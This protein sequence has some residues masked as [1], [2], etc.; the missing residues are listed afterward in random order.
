MS[1]SLINGVIWGAVVALFAF[2]MYGQYQLALVMLTAMIVNLLIAAAAGVLVPAL[3]KYVG[4]D[5]V[6]GSSVLLTAITDSMG[7]FVF[8]GL[9]AIFLV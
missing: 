7:F 9:A 1:I 2:I 5:P 3:L 6:M 4:R 8:L